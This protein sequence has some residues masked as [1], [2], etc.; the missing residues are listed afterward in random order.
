MILTR[1]TT[2]AVAGVLTASLAAAAR[3]RLSVSTPKSSGGRPKSRET[4][5]FD[6][7]HGACDSH[8]HV[9]GDP[10]RFP[11]APDRDYTPPP[12]TADALREM[13]QSLHL[14]RVVIIAPTNYATDNAATLD[15]V[16]VLG[17]DRARGIALIDDGTSPKTLDSL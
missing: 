3:M 15:A 11:M 17:R 7:P 12:A 4:P 2:L 10:S 1:R 16:N 9:I 14:D 6:V 13:L 8:V 5:S